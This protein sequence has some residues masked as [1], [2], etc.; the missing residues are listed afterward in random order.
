MNPAIIPVIEEIKRIEK[1]K[2]AEAPDRV[3]CC[4][5]FYVVR[6]EE[7]DRPTLEFLVLDDLIKNYESQLLLPQALVCGW[8]QVFST[9]PGIQLLA[10]VIV[11]ELWMAT[12]PTFVELGWEA[13]QMFN[14]SEQ[15]NRVDCLHIMVCEKEQSTSF[16]YEMVR[17]TSPMGFIQLPAD[18]FCERLFKVKTI[19]P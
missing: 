15:P 6:Y 2:R 1:E 8:D 14:A 4:I 10:I 7:D 12:L 9:K 16:L 3:R 18:G 19:F 5:G 17:S 13:D 11:H